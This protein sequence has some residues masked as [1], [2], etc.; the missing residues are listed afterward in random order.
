MRL[1]LSFQ[2]TQSNTDRG[3]TERSPA[4]LCTLPDSNSSVRGHD[5]VKMDTRLDGECWEGADLGGVHTEGTPG[6][7][8]SSI[9]DSNGD[10]PSSDF[11]DEYHSVA[12]KRKRPRGSDGENKPC[13]GKRNKVVDKGEMGEGSGESCDERGGSRSAT[14][15]RTLKEKVKSGQFVVN[16]RKR[17]AFEEKCKRMDKGVK[18]RYGDNWEVL[19]QKC[20]KWYTMIFFFF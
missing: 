6:T 12:L 17:D 19:H 3:I 16:E 15:T 1:T 20:G 2:P 14:A 5:V 18:F 8:D 13:G 10:P 9:L 4:V 11:E 7:L